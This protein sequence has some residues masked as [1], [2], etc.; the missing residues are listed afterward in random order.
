M[1]IDT[2]GTEIARL[3]EDVTLGGG[4]VELEHIE[5]GTIGGI[6]EGCRADGEG[7][8]ITSGVVGG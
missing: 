3:G 8:F 2:V 5:G 4:Y 7:Y 1:L 6:P